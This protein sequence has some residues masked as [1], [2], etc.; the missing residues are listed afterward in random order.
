MKFPPTHNLV[1]DSTVRLRPNLPHRGSM[2]SNAR[3]GLTLIEIMIALTMTLIVL[4][5]MMTAFQFASQKM[6]A[7]RA[8][9]ELA[10]RARSAESLLRAD[11]A[12]LTV[13]PRPYAQTA[14]PPGYFEYIEGPSRDKWYDGIPIIPP[15]IPPDEVSYLGDID[16]VLAM[17]VRSSGR[18]F[19]GRWNGGIIESP[20]AEVIWFTTWNDL[21]AKP[22]KIQFEESVSV[23]RRVLLIAPPGLTGLPIN[24]DMNAVNAFFQNNDVS[25]RVVPNGTNFDIVANDL[26]DLALR[27]NRFCHHLPD[28]PLDPR[29]L[30]PNVLLVDYLVNR[31]SRSGDDIVLTD[32]A[33]FD[34]R[35]YSPNINVN[36]SANTGVDI[37]AEPGDP[38]YVNFGTS[39][40]SPN[41][42]FVDLASDPTDPNGWFAGNASMKSQCS[43]T[44]PMNPLNPLSLLT[45][46]VYDTWTPFYESDG[47]DQDG[48]F[49]FDQGTNGLDDDN[50]NGVDDTAERETLPPYA[51]PIRGLQVSIRLIEKGTKQVHQTTIVHSFVPE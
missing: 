37:I 8:V 7:G 4:G 17:T 38:G 19:R 2:Q 13:E 16:D 49:S 18:M 46:N 24:I 41:G 42:A 39:A 21:D 34:L 35:V 29:Y 44:D 30:L 3:S 23:R 31:L 43:Y 32:V 20:Q 5:A 27:K 14:S 10:N 40:G 48:V 47:I 33:G 12:G 28:D 36:T 25:A 6:Q 15:I 51:H 9:M 50:S 26:N 22:D 1:L 11:L 45:T